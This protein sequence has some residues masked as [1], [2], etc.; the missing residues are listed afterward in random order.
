MDQMDQERLT[1]FLRL[2]MLPPSTKGSTEYVFKSWKPSDTSPVQGIKVYQL[3]CAFWALYSE[4]TKGRGV[5]LSERQGNAPHSVHPCGGFI[6][7]K[8]G[9]GKTIQQFAAITLN[10][11]IMENRRDVT[12]ARTR[13]ATSEHL[14]KE[15]G[16]KQTAKCPTQSRYG[17]RCCCVESSPVHLLHA[18]QGINIFVTPLGVMSDYQKLFNCILAKSDRPYA[19]IKAH[20]SSKSGLEDLRPEYQSQYYNQV[21]S[22]AEWDEL[23]FAQQAVAS[24]CRV[25]FDQMYL[26]FITTPFSL[27]SQIISKFNVYTQFLGKDSNFVACAGPITIP[28]TPCKGK[29]C[30]S[31]GH[32]GNWQ[33]VTAFAFFINRIWRDE[34]HLASRPGVTIHAAI[35]A[36]NERQIRAFSRADPVV[37][38]CLSGTPYRLSPS[39]LTGVFDVHRNIAQAAHVEWSSHRRFDSAVDS[40]LQMHSKAYNQW[41]DWKT[42]AEAK[43]RNL[44]ASPK[45]ITRQ[46]KLQWQYAFE[47]AKEHF[48]SLLPLWM[49]RRRKETYFLGEK[50]CDLPPITV[51]PVVCK[52]SD[53]WY[54]RISAYF[55]DTEPPVNSRVRSILSSFPALIEVLP[56]RHYTG[57]EKDGCTFATRKHNAYRTH[58]HALFQSSAKYKEMEKIYINVLKDYKYPDGVT[59]KEPLVVSTIFP[60]ELAVL[61]AVSINDQARQR[62]ISANHTF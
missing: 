19:L 33:P 34:F 58:F 31:S 27:D 53:E 14:S 30:R 12:D 57:N 2:F 10:N 38:W 39:G 37:Y 32:R 22:R 43:A 23:P 25:P 11:E 42:G 54:S 60:H 56:G 28:N 26:I 3:Y 17:F 51:T 9:L 45:P 20:H 61:F 49:I 16:A 6:A 48:K 59:G 1:L 50:I 47:Q 15:A 40:A 62:G 36:L 52:L 18:R 4:G 21:R 7:D 8:M 35:I 46:E 55:N 13:K 29:H 41:I 24:P 44:K 5:E